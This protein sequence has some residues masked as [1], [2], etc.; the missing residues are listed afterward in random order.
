M[1][2][3][4]QL[5]QTTLLLSLLGRAAQGFSVFDCQD[6]G[7]TFAALD[8]REPAPCPEA[9]RIFKSNRTIQIQVLQTETQR[10]VKGYQCQVWLTREVCRCGFNS[11]SYGC[12]MPVL[13][14]RVPVLP[15]ACRQAA[16]TGQMKAGSHVLNVTL[17]QPGKTSFYTQGH[18]DE[19]GNCRTQ[20]FMTAGIQ[21]HESYERTTLEY[22]VRV[23]RGKV[24]TALHR[25]TFTNGLLGEYGDGVMEDDEEGTLVWNKDL[26]PCHESVSQIYLGS[27]V[28]HLRSMG[29]IEMLE[30][31]VVIERTADE[32]YAGLVLRKATSVC[33]VHG[34][35]TQIRGVVVIL[36]REG[37]APIPQA[38]FRERVVSSGAHQQGQLAYLHLGTNLAAE[39][40]AAALWTQICEVDRRVLAGRLQALAGAANPY[41]LLDIHGPGHTVVTAGAVAYI[42]KCVRKEATFQEYANCTEEIPVLVDNRTGFADPLTRVLR[43]FPT[44][45]PCDDVLPVR[46]RLRDQWYCATPKIHACEAPTQLVPVQGVPAGRDISRGLEGGLYSRSQLEA[47]RKYL[48]AQGSRRAVLSKA[49]VDATNQ[50]LGVGTALGPPLSADELAQLT[51]NI[52]GAI[53]PMFTYLG[54]WWSFIMGFLLLL[55]VVK[56]VLGVMLRTWVLYLE[57]G[58]GC[59]MLMAFWHTAFLLVRIPLVVLQEA[60]RR[61]TEGLPAQPGTAPSQ[62][63][64][65]I[66]QMEEGRASA[67]GKP[68]M[69][70]E[71]P[72]Q[73]DDG[74]QEPTREAVTYQAH[75]QQVYLPMAE[76]M[77]VMIR[78][79]RRQLFSGLLRT[80]NQE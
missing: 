65:A 46:W 29:D 26:W 27:A 52:G 75:G 36:L 44:V 4:V 37:D 25:I 72:G 28:Q 53:F 58:C 18:L 17:G 70:E 9:S 8:L 43:D 62:Y 21:F 50:V 64:S 13:Y 48:V 47:H 41:S 14:Q 10:P 30:S 76:Q 12:Q 38:D 22:H 49:A 40:R 61:I 20:S 80:N 42:G 55:A 16:R 34:Y 39:E 5:T 73:Q 15:E 51:K 54:D 35:S 78:R 31:L 66:H 59:W 57:R 56:I 77:R 7:T 60:G 11:L 79:D 45:I 33:Q 63:N 23:A 32:Q 24:D 68:P 71:H 67:P 6:N 69:G 1:M 2:T 19:E 3:I 74:Q